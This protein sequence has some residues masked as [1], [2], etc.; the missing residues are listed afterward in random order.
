MTYDSFVN[1]KSGGAGDVPHRFSL[2]SAAPAVLGFYSRAASRSLLAAK[3]VG[4]CLEVKGA[5]G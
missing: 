1:R 3:T 5:P 2:V 4:V